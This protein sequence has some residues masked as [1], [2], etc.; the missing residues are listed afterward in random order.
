MTDDPDPAA[1]SR[2][3]VVRDGVVANLVIWIGEPMWRPVEG[4]AVAAGEEV[5]IGWLWTGAAFA[6]PPR[7]GR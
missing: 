3:A 6:P 1:G 2:Y 5:A 7:D 4:F